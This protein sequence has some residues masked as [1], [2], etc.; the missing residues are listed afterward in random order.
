MTAE[1]LRQIALLRLETIVEE[2]TPAPA[3]AV[4]P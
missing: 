2:N 1:Q 4:A 3:P